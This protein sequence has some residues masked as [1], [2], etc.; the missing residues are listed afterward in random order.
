MFRDIQYSVS[1]T[2]NDKFWLYFNGANEELI[3]DAANN[4]YHTKHEAYLFIQKK[5][6]LPVESVVNTIS[7][8]KPVR[9]VI[10][11]QKRAA[12]ETKSITTKAMVPAYSERR[13][14]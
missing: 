9:E 4:R 8:P 5:T 1:D 14:R 3:F 6:M 10:S 7:I 2:S 12:N 11:T 13:T